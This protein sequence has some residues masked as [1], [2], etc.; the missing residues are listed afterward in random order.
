MDSEKLNILWTNENELTSELMVIMY[1]TNSLKKEFWN[2][3]RVIIW[4][5]TAK[6]V[7]ES[8]RIQGLIKEAQ[9]EGVEFSACEACATELGVKDIIHK[10][11]IEVK[12][13]GEPLTKLIKEKEN[14][15]TI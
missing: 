15:I 14:L 3:V 10:L 8:K 1:A 9:D 12:F 7:A 5:A 11:G 2:E 6:L 4:G 13:W